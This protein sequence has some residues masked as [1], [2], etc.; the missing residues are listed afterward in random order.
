[1][2]RSE[3]PFCN[4]VWGAV[5]KTVRA[6]RAVRKHRKFGKICMTVNPFSEHLKKMVQTKL[7]VQGMPAILHQYVN[8]RVLR[9]F[10]HFT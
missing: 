2:L 6:V 5:I 1:M 7:L 8:P 9:H 3:S 10:E 4:I